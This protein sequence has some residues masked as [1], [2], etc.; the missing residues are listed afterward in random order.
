M[1]HRRRAAGLGALLVGIAA[2]LAAAGA[3]AQVVVPTKDP[4]HPRIRYTD[5]LLSMNDRC[6]VRGGT[7][8]PLF[9]PVYVNGRPVG[10]C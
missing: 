4:E 9:K 7:L 10:F 2:L 5:S 3:T 8:N 1:S 6:M